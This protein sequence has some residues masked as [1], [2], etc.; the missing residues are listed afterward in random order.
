MNI[1]YFLMPPNCLLMMHLTIPHYNPTP[2]INELYNWFLDQQWFGFRRNK[3]RNNRTTKR[4]DY[5]DRWNTKRTTSSTYLKSNCQRFSIQLDTFSS[6]REV[7][8]KC[9]HQNQYYGIT[10]IETYSYF[11]HLH[12][13]FCISSTRCIGSEKIEMCHLHSM[14]NTNPQKKERWYDST[15]STD[16]PF[17]L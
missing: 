4:R 15:P 3:T 7:Y 14:E 1:L 16:H 2:S 17:Q 8:S 11:I 12:F 13:H 10:Y 5:T 9:L 6:R